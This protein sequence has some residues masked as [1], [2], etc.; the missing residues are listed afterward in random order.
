MGG[1]V[2]VLGGLQVAAAPPY[3]AHLVPGLGGVHDRDGFEFLAGPL[4]FARC[5]VPFAP[6][7]EQLGAVHSAVSGEQR[8]GG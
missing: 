1:P 2:G 6:E 4:G 3:L 8:R 7:D 5:A